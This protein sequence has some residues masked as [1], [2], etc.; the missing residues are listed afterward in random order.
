MYEGHTPSKSK[1]N[2][3]KVRNPDKPICTV[4]K[5]SDKGKKGENFVHNHV[6]K[7]GKKTYRDSA[8]GKNYDIVSQLLDDLKGC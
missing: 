7:V 6:V 4:C 5:L 1:R 2:A 3:F 8:K